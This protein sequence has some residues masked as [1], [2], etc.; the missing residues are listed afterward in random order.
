MPKGNSVRPA[1]K[2]AAKQ[3]PNRKPIGE[4]TGV[5]LIALGIFLG[6]CVFVKTDTGLLG[7]AFR[8][9][10]FGLFGIFVY[11]VPFAITALGVAV[12]A[13]RSKKKSAGR[14]ALVIML[15]AAVFS[16]AHTFI[17]DRLPLHDGFFSYVSASYQA[18]L[19]NHA[20]GGAV[21]CLLVY[22]C[23]L[24][25]GYVGCVILFITMLLISV[26]VL[27]G[28]SLKRMSKGVVDAGKRT[29]EKVRV[30]AEERRQKRLYIENLREEQ[31]DGEALFDPSQPRE[32]ELLT[33]QSFRKKKPVPSYFDD[34][35]YTVKGAGLAMPGDP[36]PVYR[37]APPPYRARHRAAAFP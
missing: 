23:N 6:V 14:I 31:D 26:L 7:G 16:I 5:V 17:L 21:G 8:D 18:G 4:V 2:P 13:A 24:L 33:R 3:E 12:I 25:I 11:L 19:Q 28:L 35:Q 29:V 20:G 32:P 1:P 15:V 22:P 30:N 27:T 37:A 10:L 34:E 9:V 36:P